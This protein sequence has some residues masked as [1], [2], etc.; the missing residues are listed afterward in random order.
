MSTA[1][2]SRWTCVTCGQDVRDSTFYSGR[3]KEHVTCRVVR[4]QTASLREENAR[5]RAAI[6]FCSGSCGAAMALPVQGDDS[7]PK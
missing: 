3:Q 1:D 4:I 5:L 7:R 2:A 6:Q